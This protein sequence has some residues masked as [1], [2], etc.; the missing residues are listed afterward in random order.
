MAFGYLE[1][2]LKPVLLSGGPGKV[3]VDRL[4]GLPFWAGALILA[5]VLVGSLVALERFKP[6]RE[7]IGADVDGLAAVPDGRQG[8]TPTDTRAVGARS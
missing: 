1:P 2:A 6:W 4:F 5:A 3:T 7:E 8:V